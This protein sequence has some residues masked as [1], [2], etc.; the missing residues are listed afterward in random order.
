[1]FR[2]DIGVA[3]TNEENDLHCVGICS[4]YV[5]RIPS[6]STL[7]FDQIQTFPYLSICSPELPPLTQ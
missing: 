1:M 3:H 5:Q 6:D 4:S 2:Y 7:R